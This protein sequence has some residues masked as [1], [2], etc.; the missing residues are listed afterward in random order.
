[1]A[2]DGRIFLTPIQK[3]REKALID[4]DH[5]K[6]SIAAECRKRAFGETITRQ[7]VQDVFRDRRRNPVIEEV[8]SELLGIPRRKLFPVPVAPRKERK[9]AGKRRSG[10][11]NARS[12][13]RARRALA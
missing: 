8:A 4:A 5:S 6:E 12:G 10:K 3:M 9:D 2:I 1:M 11:T 13:S 7:R